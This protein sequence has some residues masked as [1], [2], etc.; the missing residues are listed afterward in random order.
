MDLHHPLFLKQI[1]TSENHYGTTTLRINSAKNSMHQ[2][3]KQ[4]ILLT[5]SILRWPVLLLL[6][7]IPQLV[8]VCADLFQQPQHTR[9]TTP[10]LEHHTV[11]TIKN[12]YQVY[13]CYRFQITYY[14][15]S[16]L[17]LNIYSKTQVQNVGVDLPVYVQHQLFLNISPLHCTAP[18]SAIRNSRLYYISL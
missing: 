14:R 3:D 2:D 13:I 10:T 18:Y 17:S 9:L 12:C 4:L 16:H 5:V 7:Y 8:T 6:V 15:Y 11:H 1:F